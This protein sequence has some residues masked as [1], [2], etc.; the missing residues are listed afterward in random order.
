MTAPKAPSK[1]AIDRLLEVMGRLRDPVYGCPW[2]AR[3]T[4]ESLAPYAIEEAYEVYDAIARKDRSEIREELG[5]L[6]LQVVFHARIAEE[7]GSFTFEEVAEA[8]TRKLIERHPHVFGEITYESHGAQS[9]GWEDIKA[10]ER[11]AKGES[12]VLDGL[13]LALPALLRAVKLQR[14]AAKVG[15]DWPA[16]EPV[17][18]KIYEELGEL[19]AEIEGFQQRERLQDELGDLLFSVVNLARHLDLEPEEALRHA[20]R[21]FEDRFRSLEEEITADGAMIEDC[22]IDRLEEAWQRAKRKE[23][24]EQNRNGGQK[25]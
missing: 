8:I 1:A 23:H 11:A 7:E 9:R 18:Q 14:R 25:I 2:D 22:D 5:D 20:N 16:L 4:L 3:Q 24:Q 12:G 21:K 19:R 6:L 10:A 15:F 17:L 13:P